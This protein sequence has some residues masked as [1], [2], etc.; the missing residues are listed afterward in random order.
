MKKL[1]IVLSVLVICH[2]DELITKTIKMPK[3]CTRKAEKGDKL[4]V[5]YVGRLEDE[6]GK[7]FD[8]S[9]KRGN[10]LNFQLGAGQVNK[11][12]FMW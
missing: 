12:M 11:H 8:A 10:T 9:K 4:K 3:E 6:N 2:A 7:I 5:H 1:K